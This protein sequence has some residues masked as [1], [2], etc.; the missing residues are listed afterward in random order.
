MTNNTKIALNRSSKQKRIRQQYINE[1]REISLFLNKHKLTPIDLPNMFRELINILY[2]SNCGYCTKYY[3]L[4]RENR[5]FCSSSCRVR[6]NRELTTK[7]D[8]IDITYI[9]A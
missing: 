1:A 8:D 9:C 6:Y 4:T 3:P 5:R 7:I 2:I